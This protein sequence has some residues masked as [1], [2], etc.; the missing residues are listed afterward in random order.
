MKKFVVLVIIDGFGISNLKVGNAIYSA[1]T[2]ILD[3][4]FENNSTSKLQA[5]G[6]S[7]GLPG[8]QVGNSEVGHMTIG[9]GRILNQDLTKINSSIENKSFFENFEIKKIINYV[10]K[11]NSDL[12]IM[13]LLSNGGIH[14]HIEHLY[15]LLEFLKNY[16]IKNIN[17]HVWLDGRDTYCKSGINFV[18]NLE[19]KLNDLNIGEIASIS[20][21]YYSMDRDNRLDRIQKAYDVINNDCSNKFKNLVEYILNFYEND[22]TDEFIIPAVSKN[23]TGFSKKDAFICFNFRADRV[24]EIT[25]FILEKNKENKFLFFTEYFKTNNENVS[26][27]FKP[28]I[29][30]NNLSEY[31]SD[32]DLKQLKITE[33]E[34]YAHVTF[35][36]NSGV[37]KAYKN[38]DRILVP[39]PR[40]VDVYDLK[41]EMS[42]FEITDKVLYEIEKNKYDLIVLNYANCDMV[43]HTGNFLATVKAIEFVDLCIKK[44]LNSITRNKGVLIVTSDHGNAEKMLTESG[45]IFTAHTNNLVPF[46]VANYPCKLKSFGNLSD[47]APTILNILNLKKPEEMSG[48]SLITYQ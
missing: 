14:S 33:T 31:I 18:K 4:L 16:D 3:N 41:P 2:P 21:R 7:V 12:N 19:K 45:E 6:V 9:S 37:E 22:I 8:G 11:N 48:N 40:E 20:G 5:S 1:K 23:Y 36:F 43:G 35:F 15:S 26:I 46:C 17:I 13:G 25:D 32:F 39:S 24:R 27:A 10:L 29:I 44:L 42:A 38:E 34:K 28:G 30:K 47:I